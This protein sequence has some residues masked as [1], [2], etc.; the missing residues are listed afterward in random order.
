MTQNTRTNNVRAMVDQAQCTP[1]W[2]VG[3]PEWT[4]GAVVIGD[5]ETGEHDGLTVLVMLHHGA[6]SVRD[7][8][9][10]SVAHEQLGPLPNAWQARVG[11]ARLRC[12]AVTRTGGRC[13]AYVGDPGR[14]C[15]HHRGAE[16]L[17]LDDVGGGT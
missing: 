16:Q 5:D 10:S 13:R 14:R 4:A 15:R 12:G 2:D 3:A 8:V 9:C 17:V 6:D 1:L 11:A 7:L